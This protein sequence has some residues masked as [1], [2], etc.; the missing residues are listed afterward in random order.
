[1]PS[2]M[3]SYSGL[4]VRV[5]KQTLVILARYTARHIFLIVLIISPK[6]Q[7]VSPPVQFLQGIFDCPRLDNHPIDG[8]VILP[9]EISRHIL[10]ERMDASRANH[11]RDGSRDFSRSESK[12]KED[13]NG[14][15]GGW[16]CEMRK[17]EEC[18]WGH[19]MLRNEK[20]AAQRKA[21]A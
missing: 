12:R 5:Q 15:V 19:A 16:R 20:E 7:L 14:R 17:R 4:R 21:E 3:C 1:M 18:S 11:W 2:K 13:R 6:M 9:A 8:F 10:F